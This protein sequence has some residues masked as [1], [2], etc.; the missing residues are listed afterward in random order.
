MLQ[1][2]ATQTRDS[3]PVEGIGLFGRKTPPHTTFQPK[4][5]VTVMFALFIGLWAQVA[6]KVKIFDVDEKSVMA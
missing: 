4:G 1:T 6:E 3:L 2:K 5:T